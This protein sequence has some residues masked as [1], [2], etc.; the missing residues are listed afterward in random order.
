MKPTQNRYYGYGRRPRTFLQ[1]ARCGRTI[2]VVLVSN[3]RPNHFSYK[4]MLSYKCQK[5]VRPC[6]AKKRFNLATFSSLELYFVKKY[7]AV[8]A[9]PTLKCK[10]LRTKCNSSNS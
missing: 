2:F 10:T 4:G 1:N 7:S 5:F 8:V 9:L 3:M 6:T